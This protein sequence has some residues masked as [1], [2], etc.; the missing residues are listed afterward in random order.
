MRFSTFWA[1]GMLSTLAIQELLNKPDL[2]IEELLDEDGLQ[3]E[4]KTNNQKLMDM[5]SH[6]KKS[7]ISPT[8]C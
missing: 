4:I 8:L 2:E 7:H 3:V 6:I 5:Y 1:Y